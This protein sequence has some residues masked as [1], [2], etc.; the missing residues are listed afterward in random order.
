MKLREPKNKDTRLR[1]VARSY[2][3]LLLLAAV[4]T[5]VACVIVVGFVLRSYIVV[6]WNATRQFVDSIRNAIGG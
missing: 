4:V 2:R 3:E 6:T 5:V 1:Q